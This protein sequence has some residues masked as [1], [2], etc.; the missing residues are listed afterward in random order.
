MEISREEWIAE[1]AARRWILVDSLG[2]DPHVERGMEVY[3][4]LKHLPPSQAAEQDL[5]AHPE[6]RWEPDSGWITAL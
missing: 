1:F 5:R 2:P 3:E 6:Q 4:D